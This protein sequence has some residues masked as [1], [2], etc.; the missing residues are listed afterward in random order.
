MIVENRSWGG[1]AIQKLKAF[2]GVIIKFSEIGSY[3]GCSNALDDSKTN[4]EDSNKNTNAAWN[5]REQADE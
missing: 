2:V 5:S 1:N 4:L 3:V